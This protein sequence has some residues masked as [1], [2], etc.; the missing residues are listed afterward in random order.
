MKRLLVVMA[1]DPVPGRVKTRLQP[2]V[3]P[4]HAAGLYLCFLEDRLRDV[5]S[6]PGIDGAVAENLVK[7][8]S[9]NL[10]RT[11]AVGLEKGTA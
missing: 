8:T 6:L 4:A 2:R 11:G 1:K 9:T 7:P 3:S 5:A 10:V